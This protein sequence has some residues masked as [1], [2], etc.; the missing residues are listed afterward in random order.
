MNSC[1]GEVYALILKC[2]LVKRRRS[3]E[4]GTLKSRPSGALQQNCV[5]RAAFHFCVRIFFWFVLHCS[6]Q[7]PRSQKGAGRAVGRAGD[8]IDIITGSR[9]KLLEH[10][11][12]SEESV[13]QSSVCLSVGIGRCSELPPFRRCVSFEIRGIPF[14]RLATKVQASLGN[15]NFVYDRVAPNSQD[16]Q[17]TSRS[18]T[19]RSSQP[20]SP[21]VSIGRQ[22]AV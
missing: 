16:G 12:L 6:L 9:V 17:S 4:F 10:K 8:S 14:A 7:T 20:A 5:T 15:S 21:S 19:Q 2:R 3:I 22:T 18:A 1:D 13:C 11:I